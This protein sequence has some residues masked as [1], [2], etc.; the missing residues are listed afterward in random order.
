MIISVAILLLGCD[1]GGSMSGGK[2]LPMNSQ[3]DSI[4]YAFG[5]SVAKSMNQIKEDGGEEYAINMDLFNNGIEEGMGEKARLTETQTQTTMMGLSKVMQAAAQKKAAKE[6]AENLIAGQQ[7]LAENAKKE[8]VKTTASGL[9]YKVLKEGKG[10]TPTAESK[11]S[12]HYTGKLIDGKVFDSSVERGQPAQFSVNQVIKGW[13]E[14]LQ[15]MKVGSKYEFTIPA[16][17]AYGQGG[18]RGI[19]PNSVLVFEVELLDI[20]K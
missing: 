5:L 19:P 18:Q 12:V 15:L 10:A 17:L 11:V 1:K 8:G 6:G 16:E 9:Q 13:T 7:F 4:S 3:M 2:S 14:G 20:L